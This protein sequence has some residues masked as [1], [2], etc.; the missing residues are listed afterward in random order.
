MKT[1]RA[2]YIGTNINSFKRGER[3]EIVGVKW[4]KPDNLDWRLCYMVA[5]N[6]GT[7]DYK[8]IE[9]FQNY[10]IVKK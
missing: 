8:A 2:F 4:V 5:Y 3:G 9:D 10:E 7:V 1:K 6:D